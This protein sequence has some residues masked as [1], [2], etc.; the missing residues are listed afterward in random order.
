MEIDIGCSIPRQGRPYIRRR[1]LCVHANGIGTRHQVR[2]GAGHRGADDILTTRQRHQRRELAA[3]YG[4][5]L[6][7]SIHVQ[8]DRADRGIFHRPLHLNK[9]GGGRAAVGGRRDRELARVAGGINRGHRDR[10]PQNHLG[11]TARRV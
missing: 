1:N 6:H 11:T 5:R 3:G 2:G 4:N 10:R 9:S 8:L 7:G